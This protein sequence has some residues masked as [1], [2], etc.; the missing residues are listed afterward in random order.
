MKGAPITVS[1]VI[2]RPSRQRWWSCRVMVLVVLSVLEQRLDAVRSGPQ[3][4]PFERN[5]SPFN[6]HQ[7]A[8]MTLNVYASLFEDDLDLVSERLDAVISGAAVSPV[9]PGAPSASR[10]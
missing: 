8:A 7:D 5:W 2:T 1:G 9:C 4:R 10:R 6:G 3:P